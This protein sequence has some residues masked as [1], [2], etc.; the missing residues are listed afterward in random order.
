MH[1]R[2]T[3]ARDFVLG[4][5]GAWLFAIALLAH[6]P[7]GSAFNYD[8]HQRIG[9]AAFFLAV[10]ISEKYNANRLAG[11]FAGDNAGTICTMMAGMYRPHVKACRNLSSQAFGSVESAPAQSLDLGLYGMLASC[12]DQVEAPASLF[13]MINTSNSAG[14]DQVLEYQKAVE[15]ICFSNQIA[16]AIMARFNDSHFQ[17]AAISSFQLHH[18]A[19][20]MSVARNEVFRGLVQSSNC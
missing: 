8:E 20:M 12:V 1:T 3:K 10:A 11:Y 16:A 15:K 13:A 14:W 5:L 17:G 19:A 7:S 6:C 18:L 9:D 4:Q 2:S